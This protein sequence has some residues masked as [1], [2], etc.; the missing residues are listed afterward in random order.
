MQK[1]TK[2]QWLWVGISVVFVA[3]FMWL[4]AK[5]KDSQQGESNTMRIAVSTTPLSTPFIVA[6]ALGLYGKQGLSV[7]MI[8]CTGGVECAKLLM[9]GEVDLA[10]ASESVAM[11]NAFDHPELALLATF[12]E[13]DNDVK[14][15]SLSSSDIRQVSQLQ[16]KRVG[17]IQGSASEFYLDAV[18]LS[19]E[20]SHLDINKVFVPASEIVTAL[21]EGQV[22][23][24]SAWEPM[25][26]QIHQATGGEINHLGLTGLYQ[27][28]FNLLSTQP[29]LAQASDGPMQ[30]I[31]SLDQAIE[32]IHLNPENAQK[33]A[34][35]FLA[36]PAEQITW[37]WD[38]YVFRLSLGNALLSNLQIQAR[39][40]KQ[41]GLVDN[42]MPDFRQLLYTEPFEQWSELRD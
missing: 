38:D 22:D 26:Y 40:A 18:L 29:Y 24:I 15:V 21:L 7:E 19:H 36:L 16:G 41:N 14:L 27:L 37:S 20:A 3:L 31:Q 5:G 17:V 32:W 30:L 4:G 12:V 2:S 10:T 33:L 35:E 11:F 25:I 6:N 28:S 1:T 9:Q 39:W 13:S 42:D 23:A 34:A 8:P